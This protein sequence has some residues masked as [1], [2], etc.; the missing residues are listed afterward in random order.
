MIVLAEPDPS[1]MVQAIT[2]A[3]HILPQIDPQAMHIR[4]SMKLVFLSESA[5][6][7]IFFTLLPDE[8]LV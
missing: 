5:L 6:V 3:I 4:V 8:D 1:D 2:K 7:H